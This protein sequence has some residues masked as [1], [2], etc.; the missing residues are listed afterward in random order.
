[1]F[2]AE[3]SDQISKKILIKLAEGRIPIDQAVSEIKSCWSGIEQLKEFAKIDHNRAKRTGMPEAIFAE[4]KTPQQ[5]AEIFKAMEERRRT[6][7]AYTDNSPALATRVTP[8]MWEYLNRTLP[9]KLKYFSEGRIVALKGEAS[10]G[11]DS[12]GRIAIVCAGTSDLPI[13]EE[14]A[15]T[16]QLCGVQ[17]DRVYDV[18]VAGIHRLLS[19]IDTIRRAQVAICVAGMDGAMPS[20]VAGLVDCPSVAVPTSI[21]YGAAFNGVAPLLGMLNSCSP[22]LSVVNIDNGFGAAVFALKVLNTKSKKENSK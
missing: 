4:G 22:G 2:S 16:A 9:G 11:V 3:S 5:V 8:E 20:V 19:N 1:M 12:R 21:G 14:A 17:V 7:G 6:H 18:G 15:V 10:S 13:A